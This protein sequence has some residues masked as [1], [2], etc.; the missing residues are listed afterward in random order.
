MNRLYL[1]SWY[2][3]TTI[4]AAETFYN[5]LKQGIVEGKNFPMDCPYQIALLHTRVD[6]HWAVG[7]LSLPGTPGD[8]SVEQTKKLRGWFDAC[9]VIPDSDTTSMFVTSPSVEG[10]L[11]QKYG[12]A[13]ELLDKFGM[14]Q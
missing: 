8:D 7:I 14:L 11:R 6:E 5:G 10:T 2:Y 4:T 13:Y 3:D 1:I 12:S 9:G